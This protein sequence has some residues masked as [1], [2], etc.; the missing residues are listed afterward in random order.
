MQQQPEMKI[1]SL[2][3]D[4]QE[5]LAICIVHLYHEMV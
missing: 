1:Y 5:A 4:F 3:P 2:I